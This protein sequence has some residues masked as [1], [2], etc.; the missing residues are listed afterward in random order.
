VLAV[1]A[2][3]GFR[4]LYGEKLSFPIRQ[5]KWQSISRKIQATLEGD[6]EILSES[7][8]CSVTGHAQAWSWMETITPD[9][10]S[11]DARLPGHLFL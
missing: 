11:G 10:T 5:K 7:Q 1:P 4:Q 2:C 8:D 3:A 9:A 6:A